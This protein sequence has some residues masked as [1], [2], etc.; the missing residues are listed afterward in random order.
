MILLSSTETG[1]NRVRATMRLYPGYI[2]PGDDGPVIDHFCDYI[3]YR[4][5]RELVREGLDPRINVE[6]LVEDEE[7]RF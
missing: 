7:E 6:Q 2:D 4:K 3:F 1:E 5:R